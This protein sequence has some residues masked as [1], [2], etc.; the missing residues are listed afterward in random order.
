MQCSQISMK[1]NNFFQISFSDLLIIRTKKQT[2]IKTSGRGQLLGPALG[3]VKI[4]HTENKQ[5]SIIQDAYNG[6]KIGA[7]NI[8]WGNQLRFQISAH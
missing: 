8:F 3:Q 4:L 5:Q 2:M 1:S 6:T 7:S